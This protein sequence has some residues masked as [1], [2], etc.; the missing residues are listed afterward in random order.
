MLDKERLFDFL[1]GL[2]KELDEVSGR[3]SGKNHLPSIRKV[4]A[5]VRREES[6]KKVE[7]ES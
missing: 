2:S 6:R 3:I 4:F 5:E 1:Y 7:R